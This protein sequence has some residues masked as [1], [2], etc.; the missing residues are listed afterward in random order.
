MQMNTAVLVVLFDV[1]HGG[2]QVIREVIGAAADIVYLPD[3]EA[4][5]RAEVLR[6]ATVIL[7]QNTATELTPDELALIQQVRLL[8]FYTAG[9]DFIPLQALPADL[10]IAKNS[11][12]S[13]EPMAEHALALTLAAAKRLFLEHRQL[14]T[15]AFN[16]FTPNR[17]LAGRVCGIFGFGGIGVATARLM[18]AMG[19]QIYAINRRGHSAEPTDWIGTPD[20]LD[21]LLRAADVLIIAA[22]LTHATVG[23]IG[24]RE[25]ALMP[26]DAILVNLAR[27]EIIEEGALFAHLQAH[28]TF[29]A[30]LDAW[31]VE[32]IR[33]G[34]FRMQ[35]PFL[36]LPNV[37][38]SPH[39]SASVGG[40]HQVALRRAA[41]NCRRA[42][43]GEPPQGLIG[44]DERLR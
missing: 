15:G 22:P 27:G 7:A 39:N 30:C 13:A 33:H 11:G 4:A 1:E 29:T 9:I 40:W 32:P 34:A 21:T 37:I 16:Q 28:P 3:V 8:Q 20:Q 36:E 24:V 23:R 5:A 17:M 41:A 10:P 26:E 2:R 31:W 44:P 6:G 18:R 43:A 19:M 38:G 12:A 14:A 42:L 25:L 35:Y